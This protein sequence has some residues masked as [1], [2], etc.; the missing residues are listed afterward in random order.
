[1]VNM[2]LGRRAIAYTSKTPGKTQQYNYFVVNEAGNGG[3][4]CFH[5]V[6]MPGLG[7]AKVPGADRKRWLRFIGEYAAHRPQLR[8]IV[9]LIDGQ[10]GPMETDVAIM[11]MVREAA[12]AA[13]DAL[14]AEAGRTP[15]SYAIALTKVDKKGSSRALEGVR[16][17][18]QRAIDETGCPEPVAVVETSGKSK[19]GRH[20]MWRLLRPVVLPV[21]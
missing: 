14:D 5:V 21:D 1:M 18:V 9:H 19:T 8:L 20:E 6:D 17:A 4:G 2:V 11:R 13:Q 15:W 7:Y 10:V 16:A 12:M 3:E